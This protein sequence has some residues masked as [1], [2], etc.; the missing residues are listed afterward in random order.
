MFMHYMGKPIMESELALEHKSNRVHEEK[1][2]MNGKCYHR[3]I[4]K[5]WD[6]RFGKHFVPCA[7]E[8]VQGWIMHPQIIAHL[9]YTQS[10]NMVG[11]QGMQDY[12]LKV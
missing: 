9:K 2:W 6:K 1:S 8:T 12:I 11:A 7:F 4:Q 3:R 10:K 5:K